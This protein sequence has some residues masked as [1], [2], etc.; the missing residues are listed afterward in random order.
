MRASHT[1][2]AT[3]SGIRFLLVTSQRREGEPILLVNDGCI[4]LPAEKE[5]CPYLGGAPGTFS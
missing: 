3:P 4:D 2:V 1:S 5:R